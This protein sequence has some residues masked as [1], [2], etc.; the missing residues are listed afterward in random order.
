MTLGSADDAAGATDAAARGTGAADCIA[1]AAGAATEGS[2][3]EGSAG[4]TKAS[5]YSLLGCPTTRH[6]GP[7][8]TSLKWPR[9]LLNLVCLRTAHLRGCD[10]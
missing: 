2:S 7:L 4:W 9:L 1:G 3:T 5:S 10:S 8:V 6:K